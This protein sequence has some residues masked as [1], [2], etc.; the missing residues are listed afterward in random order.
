MH[1]H[2]YQSKQY[3]A[4]FGIRTPQG[5]IASTPQE[6]Q[7]I[8]VEFGVPVVIN[9]QALD[10]QRVF[11]LAP[12][13]EDAQRLAGDILAMTLS[14]VRVGTVL[15]EPVAS[16]SA[17][18]FLGI[19]GDRGSS[20][21]M[22]ASPEG[23][24]DIIQIE[25]TRPQTLIRET[26]N[27]FLGVLEFQARNL[28]SGINLPREHWS[29]FT[30]MVQNLYRCAVACDAI[31][32]EINPL[33]VT[34]NG[35]LIALGGK[36]VI[37]DNALFRQQELAAIRDVK[38]EHESAVQARSAG[39]SYVRLKGKIGCIVSGAGLGMA[40]LDLL[41]RH[42]ADGSSFLD[43]GSDIQ[44]DKISASLRLILPDVQAVLFNIFADK[45][46]CAEIAREFLAAF[47]EVQPAVPLV[48]RL[49]GRDTDGGRAVLED[50]NYPQLS[51]A[52]TTRQAVEAV[53]KGIAD[54]HFS[55]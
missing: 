24:D 5:K 26:I 49:A 30:Q 46:S 4:R 39:I 33:A 28:A 22:V 2:E 27:P 35:E 40:T 21:I 15:V 42:G 6:A 8:A 25:R 11:R 53:S 20:W 55:G 37:D 18:Y 9:A 38:A 52:L 45:A 12:T 1:L 54:V 48:I 19:Y 44:R 41:A 3:F 50:A 47:A 36:L 23:G 17:E 43:L 51:T 7:T 34:Q 14:G 29:A 16:V 10:H 31:R 32:A 13:P